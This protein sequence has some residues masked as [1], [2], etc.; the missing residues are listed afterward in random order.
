M[1]SVIDLT[2]SSSPAS[3]PSPSPSRS[4]LVRCQEKSCSLLVNPLVTKK[5][6]RHREL[7]AERAR[8]YHQKQKANQGETRKL[9]LSQRPS[10]TQKWRQNLSS[11]ENRSTSSSNCPAEQSLSATA[12]STLC[13]PEP[14][15][16]P[17]GQTED[18][19]ADIPTLDYEDILLSLKTQFHHNTVNFEGCFLVTNSDEMSYHQRVAQT[20][21]NIRNTTGCRVHDHLTRKIGHKTQYYCSQDSL[22]KKASKKH[23]NPSVHRDNLGMERDPCNGSLH[24]TCL[25]IPDSS[26]CQVTIKLSHSHHHRHLYKDMDMPQEA[27]DYINENVGYY[28]PVEMGRYVKEKWRGRVTGKQVHKAWTY[29][30]QKFWRR[31]AEQVPSVKALLAEWDDDGMK[32]II[33][34]LDGKVAEIAQDATYK[35]MAEISAAHQVWQTKIALC[36]WHLKRAVKT[37][38]S[39]PK[40]AT[41]PYNSNRAHDEFNFIDKTFT[42]PGRADPNEYEGGQHNEEGIDDMNEAQPPKPKTMTTY[43]V[44]A[45]LGHLAAGKIIVPPLQKGP[46][47]RRRQEQS[48]LKKEARK[49]QVIEVEEPE[50]TRIV[51]GS[52]DHSKRRFCP[53]AHCGPILDMMDHHYNA[54]P[55]IPGQHHPSAEGV[56]LWAVKELQWLKKVSQCLVIFA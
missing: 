36:L 3:S 16:P 38:L 31:H 44:G 2:I 19:E 24:I 25:P 41:T 20:A 6:S 15:L 40:L 56:K 12:N 18:N 35:D 46:I 27:I 43:G 37:R 52:D 42:P 26:E 14:G 8:R 21:D 29:F 4:G 28:S 51:S 30:S 54:H 13:S 45:S 47:T 49:T 53:E 55:S 23:P 9:K 22:H 48:E 11:S 10:H 5:C 7:D 39:N 17:G 34:I 1:T 50:G 32:K 33:K